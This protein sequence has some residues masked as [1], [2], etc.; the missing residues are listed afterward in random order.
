LKQ[1]ATHLSLQSKRPLSTE[2]ITSTDTSSILGPSVDV[3]VSGEVVVVH[4]ALLVSS[5]QFFRNALK[6]AWRTDT[7]KPINLSPEDEDLYTAD[8]KDFEKYVKWLYTKQLPP[9]VCKDTF[10]MLAK[11]Y[12][13]GEYIQDAVFQN[14][15]LDAMVWAVES[16]YPSLDSL[17]I[18][19]RGTPDS[20]PARRLM[21]EM[22]AYKVTPNSNRIKN[23]DPK[24]DGE[25]M[26]DLMKAVLNCRQ[27]AGLFEVRPWCADPE[28]YYVGDVE[29]SEEET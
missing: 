6:V 18:L 11:L 2:C 29:E 25:I 9:L 13:L 5:S 10:S 15:I 21:I 24:E 20:S 14:T 12:T 3:L 28:Q 19:Y 8:V 7:H 22:T 27:P 16:I 26:L 4:K 1:W 23:I 17:R